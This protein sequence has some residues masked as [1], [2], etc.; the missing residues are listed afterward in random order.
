MV[1]CAHYIEKNQI[2][3]IEIYKNLLHKSMFQ[4]LGNIF[5]QKS[6]SEA[7]NTDPKLH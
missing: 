1:L 7:V 2:D 5:K 3:I 4:I 6:I